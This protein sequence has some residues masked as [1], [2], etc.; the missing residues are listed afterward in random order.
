M[1]N[2]YTITNLQYNYKV[3]SALLN[4]S[5][6]PL[7]MA[8]YARNNISNYYTLKYIPEEHSPNSI[9]T[10]AAQDWSYSFGENYR[11]KINLI[12]LPDPFYNTINAINMS[13]MFNMCI[14]LNKIPNFDTSNVTD[15]R[16]MFANCSNLTTV[17]NFDTSNVTNMSSMFR[18]CDNLTTV[19][20]FDT[21]NVTRMSSM[22]EWC[23]KL[24]T[25]PNFDTSNVT[26]MTSMFTRCSNLTTVP[27]FNVNKVITAMYIF[28]YCTNLITVPNFDISNWT[29][30]SW[31]FGFCYNLTTVPNFNTS[32]IRSFTD[33]FINC[34]NLTTIPV[35]NTSSATSMDSM[36]YNCRNIQ[37][38]LYISSNN[39][40]SAS[41]LFYNTPNY[42]KNIYCHIN[43][44]TYNS[45]YNAM[46]NST[47]NSNWNTYLKTFE[48]DPLT[49]MQ[50][51]CVFSN[52]YTNPA[53]VDETI[54]TIFRSPVNRVYI[55]TYDSTNT[56][57]VY[58]IGP[59]LELDPYT[60]YNVSIY[61]NSP[62]A[63]N[64]STFVFG[65]G[66]GGFDP[67]DPYPVLRPFR[68][69]IYISNETSNVCVCNS[70]LSGTRYV[71]ADSLGV[72]FYL[73]GYYLAEGA[74]EPTTPTNICNIK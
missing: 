52:V 70:I 5:I 69:E 3:N 39:V 30:M 27:N 2:P 23:N 73:D 22:F 19:P 71:P 6:N 64:R 63:A 44:D 15:M 28:Y 7:N 1:D 25:I 36:F 9:D 10:R 54:S 11:Y 8:N 61:F 65:E 4:N 74:E 50:Q 58:V 42:T 16:F 18:H 20:N 53:D 26:S 43:T 35:F 37:G 41:D 66:G 72:Y 46:G 13:N 56:N 24:N 40:T 33:T 32:K 59:Y 29:S 48:N 62:N 17:P 45:I 14:Y 31:M 21:S 60:D 67:G 38:N 12:N 51:L 55:N 49:G 47:Y 68:Y 34:G 57:S